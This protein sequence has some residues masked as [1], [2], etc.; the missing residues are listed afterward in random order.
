MRIAL[1]LLLL[2]P[3]G[4]LPTPASLVAQETA[5][6]TAPLETFVLQVARLWAAGDAT[7]LID[8]APADGRILIDIGAE[9]AGSVQGRHATAALRSLFAGRESVSIR[10][11]RV[12]I[13]G[14]RPMRGFGELS[15]VSRSRGITVPQAVTLYVGTVWEE[16]GWRIR[17]IRILP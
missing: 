1:F 6:P 8:L 15:W 14:G 17:E 3:L 4:G 7:A 12:T 2:L 13:A 5:A 11:T 16:G 10:P 9:G